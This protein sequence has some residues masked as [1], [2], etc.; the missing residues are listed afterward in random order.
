[1]LARNSSARRTLSTWLM[2]GGVSDT[3]VA[4][5]LDHAD[6]KILH[7]VYGKP[8]EDAMAG[9]LV[10]QSAALPRVRVVYVSQTDS[11]L[12]EPAGAEAIIKNT[13][14]F[15][16]PTGTR[17]RSPRP[18]QGNP[19]TSHVPGRL[20]LGTQPWLCGPRGGGRAMA[21]GRVARRSVP[22]P[23][24]RRKQG[25]AALDSTCRG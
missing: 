19:S 10:R 21:V 18:R 24:W 22:R 4:K 9:L 13:G 3:V 1:V 15:S 7:R 5:L 23:Q 14:K 25:V 20:A 6:T 11:G 16:G 8:R 2:E 12:T 17:T